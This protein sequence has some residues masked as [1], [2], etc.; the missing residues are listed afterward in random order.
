L[1]SSW[2]QGRRDF[3]KPGPQGPAHDYK[4]P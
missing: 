1:F 2:G 4:A 3:A